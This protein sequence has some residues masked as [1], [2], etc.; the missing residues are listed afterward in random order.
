MTKKKFNKK[1]KRK[2]VHSNADLTFVILKPNSAYELIFNT[3]IGEWEEF[4]IESN[5]TTSLENIKTPI[6]GNG[7]LILCPRMTDAV[8]SCFANFS[9]TLNLLDDIRIFGN[10]TGA[11]IIVTRIES[12][13]VSRIWDSIANEYGY[14]T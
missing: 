9:A 11:Y 14:T 2:D 1:Q 10:P 6:Q 5:T 8:S 13:V 12:V 3:S 7:F 4:H